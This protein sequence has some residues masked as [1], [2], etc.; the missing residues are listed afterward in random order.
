MSQS[1]KPQ[2]TMHG[3]VEAKWAVERKFVYSED[4]ERQADHH[5]SSIWK[6]AA[7]GD[8]RTGIVNQVTG[9]VLSAL[10]AGSSSSKGMSMVRRCWANR[11]LF[12]MAS[13]RTVRTETEEFRK[14]KDRLFKY[15]G[16]YTTPPRRKKRGCSC[17]VVRKKRILVF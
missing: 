15:R 2:N 6:R 16:V 12:K 13:G 7:C 5:D 9:L 1:H 8:A 4:N 17:F 3:R 14:D 11:L 10:L